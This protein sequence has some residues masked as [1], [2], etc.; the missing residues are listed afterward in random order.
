MENKSDRLITRREAIASLATLADGTLIRPSTA[1]AFE[2]VT[3]KTRFCV[4]GDWGTGGSDERAIA[5]RMLD[6][7]RESALD[8]VL[9]VVDNIYPNGAG[10]RLAKQFE[11]PFGGLLQEKLKFYAALGNHDVREGRKDQC[12]Y[13]LF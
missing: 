3:S 13:P 6:T 7:H 12:D 1:L 10:K 5:K 2:T 9:T 4:L 11:D 8:F